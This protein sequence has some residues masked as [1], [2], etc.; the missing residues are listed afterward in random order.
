[1]VAHLGKPPSTWLTWLPNFAGRWL[2]RIAPRMRTFHQRPAQQGTKS[3]GQG[4]LYRLRAV[5]LAWDRRAL[6]RR[7]PQQSERGWLIV[8]DRSPTACVG[9]PDSAR[10]HT[11]ET[12]PRQSRLHQFLA[13]L[14][15]RLYRNIPD[16]DV[17]I[18]LNAP[19]ALTLDRNREREKPGK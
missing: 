8:C 12:A 19:L 10:L 3:S 9:A 17:V 7:L 6:A 14:E 16:P 18:R 15:N 11:S 1:Q 4:L 5:L 2:G 13:N